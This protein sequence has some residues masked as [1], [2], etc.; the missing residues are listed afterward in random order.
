MRTWPQPGPGSR[1]PWPARR[2]LPNRS[3]AAAWRSVCHRPVGPD[4]EA[5]TARGADLQALE[6]GAGEHAL[7]LLVVVVEDRAV[8]NPL[9]ADLAY[10]ALDR[11]PGREGAHRA[12]ASPAQLGH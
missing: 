11:R 3:R 1:R 5:A 9:I 7:Q 12:A 6:P 2:W 8:A 4:Q 10:R